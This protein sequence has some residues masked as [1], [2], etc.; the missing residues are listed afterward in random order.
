MDIFLMF[1]TGL[2]DEH[3]DALK[4]LKS[5]SPFKYL[6]ANFILDILMSLL[7]CRTFDDKKV[8]GYF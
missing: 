8:D 5:F 6:K 3:P 1:L 7:I 4:Q 2:L